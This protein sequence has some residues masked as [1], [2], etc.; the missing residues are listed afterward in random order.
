MTPCSLVSREVPTFYSKL[1][2]SV[3]T[4]E[5]IST[6]SVARGVQVGA[7]HP[8]QIWMHPLWICKIS[9]TNTFIS[10]LKDMRHSTTSTC[11]PCWTTVVGNNSF[12]KMYEYARCFVQ[13]S[14]VHCVVNVL[15]LQ[16]WQRSFLCLCI[17]NIY[18][19]YMTNRAL[20]TYINVCTYIHCTGSRCNHCAYGLISNTKT[21]AAGSSTI[22]Y[23]STWWW[24]IVYGL[25]LF[26]HDSH[27]LL[28]NY[29]CPFPSNL[30]RT[31]HSKSSNCATIQSIWWSSMFETWEVCP[32]VLLESWW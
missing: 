18:T 25:N 17:H 4:V 22:Q 2:A 3:F 24:H 1:H 9:E 32:I 15:I 12:S 16:S 6:R 13:C 8:L 28:S 10:P 27:H 23:P 21:K 14:R 19:P 20:Y 26:L 29:C 31:L 30:L 11:C 7:V 5:A